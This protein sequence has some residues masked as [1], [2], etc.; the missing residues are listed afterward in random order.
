MNATK[1]I[2]SND[3]RTI[4]RDRTAAGLLLVPLIFLVIL[5]FGIPVLQ[6][7]WP[8]LS[9]YTTVLLALFCVI[10]GMFPA[11]VMA[12]IM[13]DERDQGLVSAFKVLPLSAARFLWSR[14]AMATVLG[15]LYSLLLVLGAGVGSYGL[16]R[17]LML[18]MLCA[19]G[20][21]AALLAAVSIARN[22]IECL[23]TFKA[24]FV[25]A[26]MG[27]TGALGSFEGWNRVPAV[28]PTYWV[29]AAFDATDSSGFVATAALAALLYAL[30]IA[31][32]FRLFRRNLF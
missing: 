2:W 15:L 19:A 24:L 18:S 25:L 29:F 3:F 11:F 9:A 27:A 13:I 31:I 5:R 4:I 1:I 14:V 7:Q 21:V 28:L 23:T 26:A 17:A 30:V 6:R 22:K 16:I 20:G 12:S 32:V 10:A 8:E